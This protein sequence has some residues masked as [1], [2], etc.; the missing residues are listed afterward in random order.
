MHTDL[1]TR[2][3]LDT[4]IFIYLVEGHPTYAEPL[5]ELFGNLEQSS[6]E[7]VTSELSIAEVLVKPIQDRKPALVEVYKRL[8]APESKIRT[9]PI[10]RATLLQTAEIRAE[11]GGRAFDCIHVATAMRAR[12]TSFLTNDEGIRGPRSLRVVHLE[13]LLS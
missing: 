8:L 13:E 12:C 6:V 10:D 1:G 7:A 5:L 11:M 3:Y 4:N 9:L 2:I